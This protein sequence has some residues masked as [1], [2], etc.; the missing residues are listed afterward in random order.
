M[1]IHAAIRD[2]IIPAII[3]PVMRLTGWRFTKRWRHEERTWRAFF[4]RY[5]VSTIRANTKAEM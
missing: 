1:T 4:Y 5:I 3:A 2:H